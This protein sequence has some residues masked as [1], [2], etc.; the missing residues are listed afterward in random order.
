MLITI[1]FIILVMW[2]T[3]VLVPATEHGRPVRRPHHGAILVGV[4]GLLLVTPVVLI[5]TFGLPQGWSYRWLLFAGRLG[6]TGLSLAMLGAAGWLLLDTAFVWRQR[7][8][9][10]PFMFRRP[11]D[12]EA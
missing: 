9:V 10:F 7:C 11:P 8:H 5:G 1:G 3:V 6:Y 4:V 2:A 12:S